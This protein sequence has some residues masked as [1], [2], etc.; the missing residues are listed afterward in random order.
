MLADAFT[1]YYNNNVNNKIIMKD[2]LATV[3]EKNAPS[4]K[5]NKLCR[6]PSKKITEEGYTVPTA[7]EIAGSD[8]TTIALSINST[9]VI[10]MYLDSE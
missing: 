2:S 1:I 3:S 7:A 5:Y 4:V 8:C 9:K 6:R 10:F